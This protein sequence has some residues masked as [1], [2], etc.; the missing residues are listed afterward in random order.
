[1]YLVAICFFFRIW[2]RDDLVGKEAPAI[3][4]QHLSELFAV[5]QGAL[6]AAFDVSDQCMVATEQLETG[7]ATDL[8]D[9]VLF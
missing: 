4:I 2:V 1:V 9:G 5:L 6:A 7:G 3:L 8:G